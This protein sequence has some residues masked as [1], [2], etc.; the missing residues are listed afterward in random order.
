MI[1]VYCKLQITDQ[2]NSEEHL[3]PE[4]IGGRLKLKN[5]VCRN[6]NNELG[7]AVDAKLA[8]HFDFWINYLGVRK[9]G[10]ANTYV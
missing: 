1:C 8:K 4:A 10:Q 2:N 9:D 6:C 5:L 3:I 7:H